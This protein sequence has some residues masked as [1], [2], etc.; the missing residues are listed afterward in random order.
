MRIQLSKSVDLVFERLADGSSVLFD[1]EADSA[2]A[3]NPAATKVWEVLL[4][5][6][7]EA[8]VRKILAATVG[9]DVDDA[10]VHNTLAQ[11]KEAGLVRTDDDALLVANASRRETIRRLSLGFAVAMG[12]PL[13]ETLT[14]SEQRAH[15]Q[16]AGSEPATTGPVPTTSTSRF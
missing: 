16:V 5:G 14:G 2:H 3:L 10:A 1:P 8:S 6:G 15:A 9:G 13:I 11:F 12:F 4:E 7:G